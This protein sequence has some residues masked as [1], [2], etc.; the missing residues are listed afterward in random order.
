MVSR[1]PYH[2]TAE[3]NSFF[4][5]MKFCSEVIKFLVLRSLCCVPCV[6]FLVLR[7]AD[8]WHYALPSQP[9]SSIRQSAEINVFIKIRPVQLFMPLAVKTRKKHA[10]FPSEQMMYDTALC[11]KMEGK[12]SYKIYKCDL[13]FFFFY[14]FIP[15]FF[16][17]FF[18]FFVL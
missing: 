8:T 5:L 16:L 9:Q 18:P 1:P 17:F 12:T 6:A 10:I 13:C 11:T 7:V 14:V 4:K 15:P 2:A 3:G